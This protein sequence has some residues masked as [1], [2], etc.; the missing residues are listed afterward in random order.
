MLVL[1]NV[2]NEWGYA[3]QDN[4]VPFSI[5][6]IKAKLPEEV[7]AALEFKKQF[8]HDTCLAFGIPIDMITN[9]KPTKEK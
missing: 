1:R 9:I 7:T 4:Y 2:L 3:M 8:T 5:E 6:E